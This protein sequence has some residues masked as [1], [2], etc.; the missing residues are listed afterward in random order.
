[1]SVHGL[2][3]G[4]RAPVASAGDG[5]SVSQ[6]RLDTARPLLTLTDLS[7][8]YRLSRRETVS[9]LDRVS[10]EVDQGSVCALLGPSGCGKSTLLRIVAGLDTASA[11]EVALNGKPVT[12]PSRE[13]GMVFQ[14]YTS[15]PW[16]TVRQNVEY[17]LRLHGGDRRQRRAA[18]DHY[19]EM[20]HLTDFAGAYPGQLSGGMRQRVALARALAAGPM[21]LLMDEPFGALDADTRWRMQEL[22]LEIVGR[23]RLTAL[24]VTHDVEEALYLADKVVLLSHRPG[25]VLHTVRPEFRSEAGRTKEQIVALPAYGRLHGDLLTILRAQHR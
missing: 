1:M 23:H 25:R 15:F 24:I 20:V 17:G 3:P 10:F 21:I 13:R 4:S 11:G 22:L 9:A 18:S 14:S 12:G 7:K 8:H 16:L 5:E 19:L 2:R 6:R